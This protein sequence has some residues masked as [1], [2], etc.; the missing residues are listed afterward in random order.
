MK[1]TTTAAETL[2]EP[3][4]SATNEQEIRRGYN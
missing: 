1:I 4:G 2:S 3:H